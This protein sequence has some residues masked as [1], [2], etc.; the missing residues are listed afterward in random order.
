MVHKDHVELLRPAN[1]PPGGSWAD[2]GA[3]SGA[4]TLALRELIGPEA[5]IY[6]VD[7]DRSRLGDLERNHLARF[8]VSPNLRILH[9]DFTRPLHL[10]ELDGVL[11]ANSLHFFREK[12]S[13][14]RQVG[15][16]LKPDGVLLLVEYNVDS[17][18]LWVP[19]PLSFERFKALAPQA[20]YSEPRL[21]ATHP[22]SFLRGFYSALA[23]LQKGPG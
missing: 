9:G 16:F 14:L 21:L 18:N 5:I 12:A 6:A 22:S 8:G 11:M 2:L 19:Y 17:G 7:R 4:F 1:L 23:Y 13:V 10:P 20:G 15:S 3:G